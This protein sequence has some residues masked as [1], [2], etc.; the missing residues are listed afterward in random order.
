[1]AKVRESENMSGEI[2]HTGLVRYDAM[3]HAIAEAH[4]IDEVKDIRD[5]ALALERYAQQAMNMEAERKACEIRLRA[6]RKAGR[7]CGKAAERGERAKGG[8]PDRNSRNGGA[9]PLHHLQNARETSAY[10]VT[11]GANGKKL[12][13]VPEDQFEDALRDPERKPSTA[14]ILRKA[15]GSQD[16]MNPAALW[17]WGRLRD[18]E[19]DRISEVS[20][21]EL[22]GEMTET[23]ISDVARIAPVF[24]SYLNSLE[25]YIDE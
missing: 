20:P 10:H 2:S 17:L 13:S 1:M 15:N 19:R 16:Q 25:G 3:C 9:R 8:R 12:A 5:K 11:S 23:M 24:A 7:C 22:I 14:G 18:F 6:E 21:S 4:A